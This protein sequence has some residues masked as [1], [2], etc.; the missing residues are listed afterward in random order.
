MTSLECQYERYVI[1]N[2][3][4][5]PEGETY[6]DFLEPNEINPH[7]VKPHLQL[8]EKGV[9]VSA[10]TERSFFDLLFHPSCEG[11]VVRD[12]NPRVKAYVDFN[13]LLLRISDNQKEYS[14]LSTNNCIEVITAKIEKGSLPDKIRDYYL[15][16]L[17]EFAHVYYS[18]PKRWRTIISEC[19]TKC[20]YDL[21][22]THF[23]HL[24]KYA[25]EGNI[26]ATVGPINELEFLSNRTISVVDTSNIDGYSPIDL[27]VNG[28]PRVIRTNCVSYFSHKHAPLTPSERTKF[29]T[30]VQK[31]QQ[32]KGIKNFAQL[33]TRKDSKDIFNDY[34]W[35]VYSPGTLQLLEKF[36]K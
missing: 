1:C 5:D 4:V 10:G 9:I 11:L 12:L 6:G 30:L 34:A 29:E 14:T 36:D 20:R 23:T 22:H 25:K 31:I 32:Q 21:N 17:K 2:V 16:N 26:I 24:Q 13:T 3:N 28:N 35:R 8:A 15:K 18:T 7:R 27:K 19:F 33:F